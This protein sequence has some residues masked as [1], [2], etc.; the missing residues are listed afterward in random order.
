MLCLEAV[1]VGPGIE[2]DALLGVEL[3][4]HRLQLIVETALVAV[5]PEDN[6][7]VVHVA[8]HHLFHNLRAHNR[9]VRPM[10]A[11]LFAL[12]IE[13]Q[14]V[15][16]IQELRVGGI[17]RQAHRI[18]IHRLDE[19][20]VLNVLLLRQRTTALRAE[21]MTIHALH[22]NLLAIDKHTVLFVAS[23]RV[24]IF[25]GAEAKLLA[26]H[27]QGLPRCILQRKHRRIQVGLLSIPQFGIFRA[28]LRL[29]LVACND[30]GRTRGHLLALGIHNVN[31]HLTAWHCPIQEDISRKETVR[32]GINRHTLNVLC[33]LRDNKDRTPDAS[34]I[35]I[36]GTALG[37]VHLWIRT[38]LQHLDL[39]AVLLFAKEYAV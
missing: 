3:R 13:T 2:H 22:D 7:G 1:T 12:H 4:K 28:E 5:A 25:N 35:P 15:A 37:Q 23:I 19:E 24:A 38:F 26:L 30:V 33:G 29:S 27:M 36:V 18:H 10:P 11:R 21:R 9:L 17:V 20:H 32:L 6:R 16:G 34:E 14:R 31:E 8:R 39:Q